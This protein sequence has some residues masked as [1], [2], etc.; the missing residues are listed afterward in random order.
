MKDETAQLNELLSYCR[1]AQKGYHTAA[2]QVDDPIL[3]SR[4]EKY[5]LQHGEF[6]YELEQQL[7]ILGEQP[8]NQANITAEA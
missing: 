7:L 5:G 2:D 4:F 3:Q 1:S 8:E 6:A